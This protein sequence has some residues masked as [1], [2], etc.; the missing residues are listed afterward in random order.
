[1]ELPLLVDVGRDREGQKRNDCHDGANEYVPARYGV[2]YC[3]AVVKLGVGCALHDA[4]HAQEKK[5]L[6]PVCER[7]ATPRSEHGG[8]ERGTDLTGLQADAAAGGSVA[9]A[10]ASFQ[11]EKY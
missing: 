11:P 4:L 5:A 1:M 7:A 9:F 3:R 6:E 8:C 10:G 2:W